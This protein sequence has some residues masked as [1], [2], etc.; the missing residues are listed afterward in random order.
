M[1]QNASPSSTIEL[2]CRQR[3]LQANLAIAI[4]RAIPAEIDLDK[5]QQRAQD[6]YRVIAELLVD[7]RHEFPGPDG[8][9]YD[10]QGRSSAY[11]TAVREAYA[12]AGAD[13][14][15]PIPKRLTAGAAY[16]VRKILIERYGEKALYESGII[17]HPPIEVLR[18]ADAMSEGLPRDPSVRLNTVVGILNALAID[19]RLIPSEE[20]VRSALRAVFLLQRKLKGQLKALHGADA[21]HEDLSMALDQQSVV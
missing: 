1:K 14:D 11:R 17:R 7:L 16:W 10:L 19:P 20:A 6:C 15:R 18:H 2:T 21:H 3:D 9:P 8:E 5:A 4:R 13:V 12:Q